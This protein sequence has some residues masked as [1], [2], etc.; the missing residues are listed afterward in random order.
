MHRV[1]LKVGIP[2]TPYKSLPGPSGPES[3]KSLLEPSDP[4]VQRV[5]ETVLKESAVLDT[6]LTPGRKAPGD[7]S[8]T[9]RGF[10]ARRARK[11]PVRGGWDPNLKVEKACLAVRKKFRRTA[12]MKYN[13]PPLGAAP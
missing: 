9:L 1:S 2:P 3:P 10:R 6:F 12:K 13:C 7:S 11:T 4:G 8:E 5:F